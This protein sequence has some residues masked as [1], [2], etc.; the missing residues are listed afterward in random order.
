MHIKSIKSH[1]GRNSHLFAN[2]HANGQ[3]PSEGPALKSR[4]SLN[5]ALFPKQQHL[6]HTVH[7]TNIKGMP[8]NDYKWFDE[9][10][11]AKGLDIGD[12]YRNGFASLEFTS[13][14]ADV[15]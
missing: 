10:D 11:V 6:P 12:H 4:L 14:V 15:Q 2:K 7:A 1:E 3:K 8:H 9:L 13:A 5:N